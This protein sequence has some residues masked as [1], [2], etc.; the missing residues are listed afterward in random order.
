M[1]IT[2]RK[3]LHRE[4]RHIR[5]RAKVKGTAAIPRL[6]VFR[7]ARYIVAQLIDDE[8][9]VTIAE[10]SDLKAKKGNKVARATVV[11][12]DIAVKGKSKGVE[13][14]VFDRGGF[15]YTGRVKALADAAREAGLKF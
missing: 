1:N 11:G 2:K 13:R 5:I 12:K 7:S 4:R 8:R 6:S 15:L 14:A 3:T 9:G 10:A